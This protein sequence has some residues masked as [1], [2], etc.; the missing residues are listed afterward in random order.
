VDAP[1]QGG[2]AYGAGRCGQC[3]WGLLLFIGAII[4]SG[5]IMAFGERGEVAHSASPCGFRAKSA[6]SPGHAV[7]GYHSRGGAGVIGIAFIQMLLIGVGFVVKGY[8]AGMLAIV[9]L[10]LGLPRPRRRWSRCR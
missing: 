5:V 4:I 3:R 1:D 2:R 8:R 10:M 9:I 7:H 6:V